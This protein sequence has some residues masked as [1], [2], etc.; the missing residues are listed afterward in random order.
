MAIAPRV[1]RSPLQLSY[2]TFV[3]VSLDSDLGELC[4]LIPINATPFQASF[5]IH[6]SGISRPVGYP[7]HGD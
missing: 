3:Q 1:W 7:E 4:L 2:Y 6:L 5:G